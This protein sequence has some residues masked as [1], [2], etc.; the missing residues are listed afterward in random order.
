MQY[1]VPQ[2]IEREAQIIGSLHFKQIIFLAGAAGIGFLL[3]SILPRPIALLVVPLIVVG[4]LALAFLKPGGRPLAD[5][6]TYALS[7]LFSSRRYL[8]KKEEIKTDFPIVFDEVNSKKKAL[9]L[10]NPD[11]LEFAPRGRLDKLKSFI[12]TKR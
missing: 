12:E 7:Y 2:F 8:W 1:S 10:E 11:L 9:S 3:W 6:L 5:V 4:G